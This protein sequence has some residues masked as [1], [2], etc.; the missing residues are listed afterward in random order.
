MKVTKTEKKG[1]HL[2]KRDRYHT[3]KVSK[4]GFNMNDAY[5]DICNST[6]QTLQK[7]NTRKQYMQTIKAGIDPA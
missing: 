1:K 2:N 6:F 5:I 3:H 7:V 4:N